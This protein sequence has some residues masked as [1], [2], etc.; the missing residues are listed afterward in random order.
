MSGKKSQ[1]IAWTGFSLLLSV[2]ITFSLSSVNA[3]SSGVES[4]LKSTRDA[5]LRQRADI[6]EAIDKKAGQVA[7]LQSEMDRLRAYLRDTDHALSSV[8]A[9]LRGR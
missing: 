7:S 2:F 4:D 1:L 8:D 9:A 5:L 3:H 6:E